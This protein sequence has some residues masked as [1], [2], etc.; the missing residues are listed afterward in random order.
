MCVHQHTNLATLNVSIVKA[1]QQIPLKTICEFI[2][3]WSRGLCECVGAKKGEGA[4]WIF[5]FFYKYHLFLPQLKNFKNFDL[6]LFKKWM[7]ENVSKLMAILCIFVI[8]QNFLSNFSYICLKLDTI[9]VLWFLDD[10]FLS[11]ES[12]ACKIFWN[13]ILR[14]LTW[15]CLMADVCSKNLSTKM[16]LS[17]EML[18]QNRTYANSRRIGENR[19]IPNIRQHSQAFSHKLTSYR[20]NWLSHT[21]FANICLYWKFGSAENVFGA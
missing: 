7:F 2:N 14:I 21:P 6:L 16:C 8:S 11:A 1:T 12:T 18:R 17:C 9:Q 3:D 5:F 15:I 4:F 10:T 19:R 20:E 13:S